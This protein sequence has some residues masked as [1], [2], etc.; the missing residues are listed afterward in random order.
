MENTIH[1]KSW[2]G[3]D[4]RMRIL[5]KGIRTSNFLASTRTTEPARK[6][7]PKSSNSD[8]SF[9][10]SSIK[11]RTQKG[12]EWNTEALHASW[13]TPHWPLWRIYIMKLD[14]WALLVG[15]TSYLSNIQGTIKQRDG[16]KGR[17]QERA[18]ERETALSLIRE[19]NYCLSR[20]HLDWCPSTMFHL[21]ERV[22]IFKG[23]KYADSSKD[24]L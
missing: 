23:N 21:L 3:E 6:S 1:T 15:R 11:K 5:L 7:E 2:A 14:K 10:L 4:W 12:Q 19:C 22:P 18:W 8:C 20:P 13:E 24:S 9:I 16:Q 17:D